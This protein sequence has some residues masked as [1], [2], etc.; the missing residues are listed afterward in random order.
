MQNLQSITT[1]DNKLSELFERA[2]GFYGKH[3]KN[4][5]RILTALVMFFLTE[6]LLVLIPFFPHR[7]VLF[8]SAVSA[9]SA[10]RSKS[11]SFSITWV[12]LSLSLSYQNPVMGG[13][14]FLLY[15]VVS[16]AVLSCS[17]LDF[18]IYSSSFYLM[19]Y[20]L[21]FFPIV[22]AG[23]LYGAK[24]ATKVSLVT[25]FSGFA[26]CSILPFSTL[27]HLTL[28]FSTSLLSRPPAKVVSISKIAASILD[29]GSEIG[30]LGTFASKLVSG[31]A[32]S[33]QFIVLLVGWLLIAVIPAYV[34]EAV[35]KY[36]H[37]ATL[38]A[39]IGSSYVPFL[40]VSFIYPEVPGFK[41]NA[42]NVL[43]FAFVVIVAWFVS[44][45]LESAR[46]V[47]R[48]QSTSVPQTFQQVSV[49]SVVSQNVQ[50]RGKQD[51]V[52]A[53]ERMESRINAL[54]R[55]LEARDERNENENN[56]EGDN[57]RGGV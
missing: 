46:R 21:E 35:K 33:Q 16:P 39:L 36:G 57:E 10:L 41:P 55:E 3:A 28:D 7:W 6:K 12:T 38:L 15:A 43:S 47:A 18:L 52:G 29:F 32:N 42:F 53:V 5:L 23:L 56:N 26:I 45:I 24:K 8:I 30:K 14:A 9:A 31:V 44:E 13:L 19:F 20:G 40:A 25:F 37:V 48:T 50:E 2:G 17:Y 11:L 1:L 34:K 27:G 22:L 51:G 49:E 4:I 54:M